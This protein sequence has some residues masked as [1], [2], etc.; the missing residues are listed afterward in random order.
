MYYRRLVE[1]TY[2]EAIA[3]NNKIPSDLRSA[4]KS[5]NKIPLFL[6][7]LALEL[8]KLQ[9]LKQK[10]GKEP[11]AETKLKQIVYDFTDLFITGVKA[12][13]EADYQSDIQKQMLAAKA[14]A[15]KDIDATA[16]GKV[17]GDYADIF[18][19]GGVHMTDERSV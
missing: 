18:K 5:H 1:E 4:L 8:D 10:Q 15:E 16:S 9:T 19:E 6:H 12:K 17:S 14:Q 13:A 7:N 3:L 11:I 2:K